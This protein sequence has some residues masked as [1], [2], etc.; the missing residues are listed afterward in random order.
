MKSTIRTIALLSLVICSFNLFAQPSV[1]FDISNLQAGP[2]YGPWMVESAFPFFVDDGNPFNGNYAY[3]RLDFNTTGAGTPNLCTGSG[4]VTTSSC[5]AENLSVLA[6][7]DNV[8]I[9]LYEFDLAQFN[10]INTV[11]PNNAWNTLGEAGDE[12]TYTGGWGVIKVNGVV[13]LKATNCRI[14]Y[15]NY[16]PAP[17]GQGNQSIGYGW[18]VIDEANSDPAWVAE[19]NPYSTGQVRFNFSSI[20]PVIQLCYGTYNV[21]ITIQPSTHKENLSSKSLSTQGG[22]I[23]STVNFDSSDASMRFTSAAWGGPLSDQKNVMLN[24]VEQIPAGTLPDSITA[25]SPFYW[26]AGTSMNSFTVNVTFD[27][28]DLGG[29]TDVSQ[30]RILKRTYDLASWQIWQDFTLVDPTHIRANNV[31]SFSEFVIGTKGD[32]LLPVELGSFTYTMSEKAIIVCWAT[33]YEQNNSGFSVEK[34]PKQGEHWETLGFVNGAG[35]STI[36]N[37]YS[38]TDRY[39]AAGIFQYRLKQIDYN[40][41]FKYYNLSSDVNIS[42]PQK[43]GI[44]NNYPNPF[45]PSTNIQYDLPYEGFVKI[46]IFD[47]SGRLVS[48]LI[49]SYQ[50]AGSYNTTFNGANLSSGVMYS[51]IEITN[52]A[53]EKLSDVHKM[54]LIK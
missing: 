48:E 9:E 2:A 43:F 27:I 5:T 26:Q 53:G 35:N 34:K 13:K 54:I 37:N 7:T 25:V 41:N 47:V 8:T 52:K 24:H 12:R 19:M 44:K 42:A 50:Q 4:I 33:L 31:T 20:S 18:G 32:Q 39:P 49:N 36:V 28:S 1:S 23:N 16:Y 21:G 40:G 3:N 14:Y 30:L 11:N 29:V 45:N 22:S 51:V 46:K 17:I 6:G 10:H 38:F 15:R